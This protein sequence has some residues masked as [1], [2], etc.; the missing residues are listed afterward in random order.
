[1]DPKKTG[2]FLKELRKNKGLTQEQAAERFH[3][4]G[5]TISRWETGKYMPDISLLI[6][7]ADLYEVDVREII[8][9]ERKKTDMNSEVKETAIK[10]A[11]YSDTKNKGT[12]K[13][14][15]GISAI[16]AIFSFMRFVT[17]CFTIKSIRSA[18]YV[19]YDFSF[20]SSGLLFLMIAIMTLYISGKIND[21]KGIGNTIL[22]ISF[23]VLI[24][25]FVLL[26]TMPLWFAPVFA[27]FI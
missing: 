9:G 25:L 2:S 15:R 3:T 13:W 19:E 18:S 14:I 21:S 23:I 11:D 5:R 26:L 8:D 1:M 24:V 17:D 16:A 4:T 6:D 22:K 12:L 20:I 10:M 7:I 27:K